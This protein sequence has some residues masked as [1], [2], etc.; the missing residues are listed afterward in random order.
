MDVITNI[1]GFGKSKPR[2]RTK[3]QLPKKVYT[4]VEVVQANT[5]RVHDDVGGRFKS[6][7]PMGAAR[8]MYTRLCREKAIRGQCTFHLLIQEITP[9]HT[10]AK[11][12]AYTGK[13]MKR[14]VP[15]V[16]TLPDGRTVTVAY[17]TRVTKRK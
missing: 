6:A 15:N 2:K 8:K 1:F 4:I 13:R 3:K 9:G 7:T 11:M 16:R 14:K 12:F 17:D 5:N 10:S